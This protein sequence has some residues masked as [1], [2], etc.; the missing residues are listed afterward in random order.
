MSVTDA[1]QVADSRLAA[2]Q[3]AKDDFQVSTEI[4]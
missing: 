2:R 1:D 4:G 3:A